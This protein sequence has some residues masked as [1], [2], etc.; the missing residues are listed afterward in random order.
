[1]ITGADYGLIRAT[2]LDEGLKNL[3]PQDG[4]FN[5]SAYK[6][7]DNE[8]ADWISVGAEVSVD[9]RL[10]DFVDGRPDTVVI[11][12]DITHP[13][14]DLSQ[15]D[16]KDRFSNS[17]NQVYNRVSLDDMKAAIANGQ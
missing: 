7:L 10:V 14:A 5:V 12:Y 2:T 1:M 16:T 6:T 17:A 4:N 13:N 11:E 8:M 3:F 15:F 9:I